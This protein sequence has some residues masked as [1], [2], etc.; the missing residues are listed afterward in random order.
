MPI[1]EATIKLVHAI[2]STPANA[3]SRW[4]PARGSIGRT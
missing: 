1:A 3:G 4:R 2:S